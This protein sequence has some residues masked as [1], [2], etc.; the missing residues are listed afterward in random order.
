MAPST[1]VVLK[2]ITKIVEKL[3]YEYTNLVSST[4]LCIE[5]Y[6]F[7]VIAKHGQR[8]MKELSKVFFSVL[9]SY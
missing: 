3:I 7:Q 1:L 2:I 8:V 9:F 4:K 6:L 5:S